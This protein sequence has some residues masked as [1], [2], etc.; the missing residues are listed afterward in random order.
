MKKYLIL[1]CCLFSAFLSA[2][3]LLQPAWVLGGQA[4]YSSTKDASSLQNLVFYSFSPYIAREFGGRWVVGVRALAGGAPYLNLPFGTFF[5]PTDE[6]TLGAGIWAR[7]TFN[8]ANALQ[9][10]ASPYFNIING[11][12]YSLGDVRENVGD[13][14][15]R[16]LGL[17]LGLSYSVSQ[18]WRFLLR[19]GGVD[20]TSRE[21][22]TRFTGSRKSDTFSTNFGLA[23]LGLGVEYRF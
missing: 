14:G 23:S 22:D 10:Y 15:S 7:Y 1:Y 5:V 12:I 2:Q 13:T 16:Q 3:Q 8:P 9:F 4:S 19:L 18:H 20:F 11:E 17:D 6:R 21:E